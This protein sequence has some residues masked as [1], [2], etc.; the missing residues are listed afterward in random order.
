MWEWT[1]IA[2]VLG[3]VKP[4]MQFCFFCCQQILIATGFKSIK[5]IPK[6]MAR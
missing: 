1:K 4:I 6:P 5:I 2:S 3:L